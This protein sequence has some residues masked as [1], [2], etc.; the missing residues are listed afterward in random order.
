MNLLRKPCSSLNYDYSRKPPKGFLFG[1]KDATRIYLLKEAADSPDSCSPP[2][3]DFT[4]SKRPTPPSMEE[5]TIS[6]DFSSIPGYK[7]PQRT[8]TSYDIFE[9]IELGDTKS[10]FVE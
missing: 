8:E 10:I 1:N 6:F 2:N 9:T 4:Y 7:R 5:T 3:S